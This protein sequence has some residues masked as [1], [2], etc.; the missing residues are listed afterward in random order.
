MIRTVP[1]A[2]RA[3]QQLAHRV[4]EVQRAQ[5]T[6][7]LVFATLVAALH[8]TPACQLIEV[9]EAEMVI[10]D[11]EVPHDRPEGST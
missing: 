11:H 1:I 7:N 2:P 6:A 4:Q 8:L 5:E 9:R 10:E 3:A